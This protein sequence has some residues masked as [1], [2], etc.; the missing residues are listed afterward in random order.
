M[1]YFVSIL[2]LVLYLALIKG[3]DGFSLTKWSRMVECFVWGL[4]TC[5]IC[6]FLGSIVE[7]DSELGF[8]VIEELIK[9]LPLVVA[10]CRRRTA[11]FSET[12]MYGAAIGS[13]FALLENILYVYFNPQFTLGDAF[14]RGFGTALL[15]IG[16]S[17]LFA[18]AALLVNRAIS[19]KPAAI[20]LFLCV[21]AGIPSFAIHFVY[22][23]FL[24]PEMLQLV[25][26]VVLIITLICAIYA[27]DES[28]IHKWLDLCIS[29]DVTLYTAIKSGDLKNTNAGH[30]LMEA[31]ERFQP[32]V[33]F[34]ICVYLGLYLEVSIAAKSRMIMKEAG[35]DC[36]IDDAQHKENK[37]KLS[38]LASL[39]A[40]IGTSGMLFLS[41]LVNSKAVDEWVM[42]ELI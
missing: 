5:V 1:N 24:L 23:L 29:N 37:A 40:T 18:S 22:N 21:F 41:P 6:F 26:T 31:K 8:P 13:G 2:P 35:V 15:H 19:R 11:F 4:A 33:F 32:E 14:L 12:V 3:F 7:T 27:I 28:L 20:K 36:P 25:I 38:E 39:R 17:A 9:C 10:V 16:C 30:Y 34:D 42:N